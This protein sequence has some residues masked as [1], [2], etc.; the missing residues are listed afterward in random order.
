MPA[1]AG[2]CADRRCSVPAA[3]TRCSSVLRAPAGSGGGAAGAAAYGPPTTPPLA[4]GVVAAAASEASA[5][6]GEWLCCTCQDTGELGDAE[7]LLGW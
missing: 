5:A 6:G 4:A 1:S 2:T 3:D 7:G